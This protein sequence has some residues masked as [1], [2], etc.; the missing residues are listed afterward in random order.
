LLN[1]LTVDFEEW[2][3]PEYVKDKCPVSKDYHASQDI[4]ATLNLLEKHGI[5]ATF[6]VVGEI[7]QK[8]P[9]LIEQIRSR[10]H[11]IG[12]HGFD[13]EPLWKKDAETLKSE[14]DK[15]RAAVGGICIGYRAPSF[16][17]SNKTKWA[18]DVLAQTGFKY[19]SS[20]FPA[21]TPLYGVRNA[22]VQ[23]YKPSREDVSIEDEN[24]SLWEF[25]L[26][27]HSTSI[28]RLPLAGGFYLRFFPLRLIEK[29]I[30]K[31]N[32][33]GRPAVLFVHTWELNPNTP[34]LKLGLYRSFVTY[35]NLEKTT[36]K[37][38]QILPQFQFT[39][40]HTFMKEKGLL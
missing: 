2:Y 17:L 39:S 35:H 4:D 3:H 38:D 19:D 30:K 10:G 33:D 25:P 11:E 23:P 22:P 12:C 7:A 27:V 15:F 20:I 1:I 8:I 5:E 21:S 28:L 37:L 16:S 29:S 13:H 40:V 34:K 31:A 24:T 9:S 18:L 36:P 14:I 32:K 26:H 6:F